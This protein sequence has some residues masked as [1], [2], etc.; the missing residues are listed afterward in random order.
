MGCSP[1]D[2][3]PCL[4]PG[5]HILPPDLVRSPSSPQ[6]VPLPGLVVSMFVC[7]PRPTTLL[8]CH[9][10]LMPGH[11]AVWWPGLHDGC[12]RFEVRGPSDAGY[13]TFRGPLSSWFDAACHP[14]VNCH[15]YRGNLARKYIQKTA[16]CDFQLGLRLQK[17][18]QVKRLKPFLTFTFM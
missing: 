15:Y 18:G 11:G 14:T 8:P 10:D 7:L 2:R 6:G 5:R 9:T 3:Q 17:Q 16:L 13:R 4:S 1:L 12:T